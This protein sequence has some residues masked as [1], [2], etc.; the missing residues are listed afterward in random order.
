VWY[1]WP[2]ATLK[3]KVGEIHRDRE[4]EVLVRNLC[5]GPIVDRRSGGDAVLQ[6]RVLIEHGEVDGVEI[7][8]LSAGEVL[9]LRD[10]GLDLAV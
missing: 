6:R 2:V 7:D 5:P 9:V 3:P 1:F 4:A 8:G 10:G